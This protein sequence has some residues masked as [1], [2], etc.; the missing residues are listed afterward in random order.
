MKVIMERQSV[1]MRDDKRAPNKMKI[2]ILE[3]C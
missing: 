3:N 2:E 1:S